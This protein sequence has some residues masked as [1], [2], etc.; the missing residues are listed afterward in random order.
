MEMNGNDLG[1]D[2]LGLKNLNN[3]HRNLTAK[4]LVDDIVE[5]G[6]GVVGLRG[7]A[8]VDTGIYT[9]RSPKDKYI[10]NEPSSSDKIWWGSVY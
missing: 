10:V 1:L 4:E 2:Q 9:G 8:M 3:V 7:A 5:N 6:E